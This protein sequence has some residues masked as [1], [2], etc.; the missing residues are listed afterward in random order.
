MKQL[1]PWPEE[2]SLGD[3]LNELFACNKRHIHQR[4]EY[5][6]LDCMYVPLTY[7]YDAFEFCGIISI[8]SPVSGCGKTTN[9]DW[10]AKYCNNPCLSGNI[11]A[12]SLFRI[13]D[14]EKPTMLIDEFDSIYDEMRREI[15]NLLNNGYQK[16]RGIMRVEANDN[17]GREPKIFDAFGP[18]IV[19]GIGAD[20]FSGATASRSFHKRLTKRPLTEPRPPRVTK[21]DPTVMKRKLIRWANDN[22]ATIEK[23]AQSGLHIPEDLGDREA[24]IWEPLFILSTLAGKVWE[25][26]MY[27]I[28]VMLSN[29]AK[30]D[31]TSIP[32]LILSHCKDYLSDTKKERVSSVELVGYINKQT[33]WKEYTNQSIS[34]HKLASKLRDFGIFPETIHFPNHNKKLKGYYASSFEEAFRSYLPPTP[35]C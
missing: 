30:D 35:P 9:L 7:V 10:F 13:V 8:T 25:E 14:A 34:A 3:I 26:R 17:G 19:S 1:E 18:K 5:R 33:D 20:I 27:K 6:F 2:V 29:S 12:S 32:E 22:K 4:E 31:T 23:K 11:T 16:G 24:D 15:S 28:S 21:I